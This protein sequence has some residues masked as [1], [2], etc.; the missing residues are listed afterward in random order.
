MRLPLLPSSPP[1]APSP[2]PVPPPTALPS[3]PQRRGPPSTLLGEKSSKN[4]KKTRKTHEKKNTKNLPEKTRKKN[5]KKV[6]SCVVEGLRTFF[7][8][9]ADGKFANGGV[10]GDSRADAARFGWFCGAALEFLLQS[11]RQPDIVR[12]CFF[13]FCSF[14]SCFFFSTLDIF[15]SHF[16]IL[17]PPPSLITKKKTRKKKHQIHCHDWSTAP[18][19]GLLWQ[20]YHSSGLGTP[21]AV[22]TIHNADFGLAAIGDAAHHSQ[23][24]TTV[25][26]S[27]AHEISGLPAIAPNAHKLSGVR[28]GIDP[29]IWD[30]SNDP[31]LPLP[32]DSKTAEQGKKAAREALRQRLGLTGWGDRPVVAVVSR[33]T[34]QKGVHLIEHAVWRALD[35]GAQ[36]VLLGSAPDPK[37]QARF[38]ALAGRMASENAAFVFAFDEPLSHLIYAGADMIVMPSMFEPCGLAQLIS[39]RRRFLFFFPEGGEKKEWGEKKRGRLKKTHSFQ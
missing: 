11:G 17:F 20:N 21:R 8:E 7:V 27:Y 39:V 32:Y 37:V 34:E 3:A 14:F 33:L 31:F 26:P 29:D 6:S 12:C 19:A 9:P 2:P 24:F 4:S 5:S 10:Y 36:F 28:N 30:P 13:F 25:S 1:P 38:D 16:L 23:A 18:V 15:L 35:R 22:F